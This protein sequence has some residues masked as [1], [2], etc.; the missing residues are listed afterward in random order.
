MKRL[1]TLIAVVAVCAM[2]PSVRANVKLPAVFSDHMVLQQ[3][4]PVPVWGWAEAGEQVKVSF[5]GQ[6]KTTQA[7]ADGKWSVKLDKLAASGQPQTLSVKGK[8]AVTVQDVLVGEVWL[9]SGQSNMGMTVNRAKDFE[10]EQTAA[11]LPQIRM[12][13][14]S[15]SAA[16]TPQPQG[17]GQWEV[18]TPETV[19][20]FSATAYFFGR[21]VHK[22][23]GGPVGLI[24]SS[25]GG[26]PIEAWTSE[27]AQKCSAR[28]AADVRELGRQAGRLGSGQGEGR[29]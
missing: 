23:L 6:T 25:V 20:G 1:S 3:D 29:V 8:N 24:N 19:G 28:T 18:C 4:Q 14:E 2:S 17:R 5:A 21:E 12:F 10:Q 16:P 9:C 27:E 15:S 13:K 22:A 7:G 26:T 11:K